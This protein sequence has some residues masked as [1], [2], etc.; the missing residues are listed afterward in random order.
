M[1]IVSYGVDLESILCTL[2]FLYDGAG[3]NGRKHDFF[4]H[5]KMG[6]KEGSLTPA[7]LGLPL[8]IVVWIVGTFDGN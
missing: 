6:F 7:C 3:M 2:L 8:E 4:S 5:S 1:R